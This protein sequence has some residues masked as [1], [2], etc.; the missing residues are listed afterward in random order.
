MS[1]APALSA[2]YNYL[3]VPMQDRRAVR[4]DGWKLIRWLPGYRNSTY[5][6]EISQE[7]FNLRED[8]H[9]LLDVAESDP[10]TVRRLESELDELLA[11]GRVP[12][13]LTPEEQE[14]LRSLGYVQ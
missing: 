11:P 1:S 10:E 2:T 7:L 9:E 3:G 13:Q 6:S 8:P 14:R 4:H 5:H 12:V